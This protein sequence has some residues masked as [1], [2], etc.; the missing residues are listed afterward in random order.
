MKKAARAIVLKDDNI[1]L[2]KRHKMGKEYYTL[3]GGRVEMGETPEQNAIREV[4]EESTIDITDPRL[5]FI[6]DAGEPY[7]LQYVY[8]CT[9]VQGEPSLPDESEE[10]YWTVPDKNTYEPMWVA[11][12]RLSQIDFVSP[13]LREAIIMGLKA[14]WPSKPYEFSSRHAKRLS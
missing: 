8:L 4:K 13:L 7:G 14:G 10:T 5:V 9:Y 6:E 2:M 3:L 12:S 11:V 1:L